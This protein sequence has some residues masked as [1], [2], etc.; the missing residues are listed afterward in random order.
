MLNATNDFCS[1]NTIDRIGNK[2]NSHDI[3]AAIWIVIQIFIKRQ[4]FKNESICLQ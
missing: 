1:R 2:G 3:T 4:V